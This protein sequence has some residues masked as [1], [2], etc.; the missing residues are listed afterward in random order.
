[1]KVFEMNDCDWWLAGTA[2]EAMEDMCRTY[3]LR[4]M[5][6]EGSSPRELTDEELDKLI[7]WDTEDKNESNMEHWKC[8]CGAMADIECRWTGTEYQHHHGYPAG[9][10]PMKNI[11][12]R[13]F[14]E[15]LNRRIEAGVSK[16]ECFACTEA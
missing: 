6:S 12:R 7:F 11:H 10:I 3:G 8:D 1:M 14:R 4:E 16:P 2:Q 13:T 15:E 9:H 5:D